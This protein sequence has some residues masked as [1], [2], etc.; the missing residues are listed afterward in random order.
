M[1]SVLGNSSVS[2]HGVYVDR[3]PKRA[4]KPGRGPAPWRA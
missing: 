3:F 1:V 2:E 4:K